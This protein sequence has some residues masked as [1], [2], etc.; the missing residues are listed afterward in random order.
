MIDTCTSAEMIGVFILLLFTTDT[1]VNAMSEGKG[2]EVL[3]QASKR[4]M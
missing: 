4:V 2:M 1:C 3:K